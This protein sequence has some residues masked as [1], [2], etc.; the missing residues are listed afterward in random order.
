[1]QLGAK[2]TPPTEQLSSSQSLPT[3]H[4]APSA[5][6]GQPS[7]PQS[8]SVSV[9]FFTPSLQLGSAHFPPLQVMLA[10]S[11]DTLQALPIPHRFMQLPPQSTSDS[12]PSRAPLLH[13]A[14]AA[15]G[16]WSKPL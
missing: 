15:S 8:L 3:L 9:P 6:F 11:F 4:P 7:P 16:V 1:M 2:Q 12:V 10:Q 13:A 14:A 5:H